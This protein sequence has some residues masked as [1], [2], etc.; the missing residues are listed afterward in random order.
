MEHGL[1]FNITRYLCGQWTERSFFA[2][3]LINEHGFLSDW[4]DTIQPFYGLKLFKEQTAS[5]QLLF[6]Q[7]FLP[8]EDKEPFILN[9]VHFET[10]R[11][12]NI[13]IVP[14]ADELCI[15]FFDVTESS[16]LRQE[17]QQSRND[18]QLLYEQE[19]RSM[20]TLKQSYNELHRQKELAE[21]A[22]RSKSEFLQHITHDL[23]T[24]LTS[25]LGF[26]QLLEN[27]ITPLTEAQQRYVQAI[28][29]SGE[30]QLEL[31]NDLLDAAKIGESKVKI[32]PEQTNIVEL[33]EESIKLLKPLADKN[34]ISFFK[35][36]NTDNLDV[37]VDPKRF[38]QIIINLLSNAIKYNHP[39]GCII[40]SS[41][42]TSTKQL[43]INI[44]DTGIGIE[45]E[46]LNKVFEVFERGMLE[47]SEIEGTGIGLSISKQL[48]ELMQGSIDVYSDKG[49]GSLFWVE[50][51]V[52]KQ[53][54]DPIEPN[55]L[56]TVL[57]LEDKPVNIE[58]M[59]HLLKQ[60]AHSKLINVTNKKNALNII[61]NQ[62]ISVIIMSEGIENYLDIF[63]SL[64]A[65]E[66]AQ[67]IPTIILLDKETS[68][69]QIKIALEAGFYDY[70]IKPFDF[71]FAM[72]LFN[73]LALNA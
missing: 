60:R 48:V 57:Y 71:N 43:S 33:I 40:I 72:E 45:I 29:T 54:I 28:K 16:K 35:R 34:N 67:I 50:F 23:K 25:V 27:S 2:Y 64:Q 65:N 11:A 73:R 42:I 26:A 17:L 41:H 38:K 70:L 8:Y 58:L 51:P 59:K 56:Q 63:Q 69:Q 30:F 39:N 61:N 46:Q 22:N 47:N 9:A 15:L 10:G 12:A 19:I 24:P 37:F 53:S 6:L 4:S 68:P 21:Q 32:Y 13:H 66:K 52:N 62:P 7:G 36:L 20:R 49:L 5:E 14:S 18:T 44:R 3:I 55:N 1:P 31:I